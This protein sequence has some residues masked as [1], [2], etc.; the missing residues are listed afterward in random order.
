MQAHWLSALTL[1]QMCN[2]Q[3]AIVNKLLVWCP[4]DTSDIKIVI[5]TNM[6]KTF[7]KHRLISKL[8]TVTNLIIAHLTK[9]FFAMVGITIIDKQM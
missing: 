2:M 1:N 6:E 5:P 3:C 4:F 9:L 8:C 7:Y